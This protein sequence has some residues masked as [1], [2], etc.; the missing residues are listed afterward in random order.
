VEFDAAP[1][2]MLGLE[3]ALSIVLTDTALDVSTMVERMSVAPARI[4]RLAGQGGPI[5]EGAAANLIVFDPAATWTVEPNAL[6]SKSRN[7]PFA[8]RELK[9]KVL[10]TIYRGRVVVAE[11]RISNGER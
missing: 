1:C 5:A 3:T 11:G 7:T 9:G 8:G 2:G 10:W 6:A 4:R